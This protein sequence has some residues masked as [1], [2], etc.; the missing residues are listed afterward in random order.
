M[1]GIITTCAGG[2][3][4]W[5]NA[6][7]QYCVA[8]AYAEEIGAELRTGDW[9]G[10][11]VFQN[12]NEASMDGLN[13]KNATDEVLDGSTNIHLYGY[14]QRP[15]HLALLSRKKI[16]EWLKPKPEYQKQGH[17]LV[18][19]KRRSD[20]I[21]N[22]YYAVITDKS[23]EDAARQFGYNPAEATVYDCSRPQEKTYHDFFEIVSSKK[24][25]RANSTYS[26][27][28]ALLSDA[29]VYSPLV[30]NRTGWIDCNFIQ[31][32]GAQIMQLFGE[33][34]VGG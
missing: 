29:N 1:N 26:W 3:G 7:F 12:V 8:R 32:N 34:H 9:M 19:H 11:H 13:L 18:F 30:E 16:K 21:D 31:G 2:F 27:W 22:G 20:Y 5:G 28:A 10:R 14:F 23:Y 25:F 33:M 15:E 17:N 24:I 6:L 4:R